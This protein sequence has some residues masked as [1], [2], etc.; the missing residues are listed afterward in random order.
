VRILIENRHQTVGRQSEFGTECA[1]LG[2]IARASSGAADEAE[3][4]AT[5][6]NQDDSALWWVQDP[7][8]VS[9]KRNGGGAIQRKAIA[10][11]KGDPGMGNP[12][13]ECKRQP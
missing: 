12:P 1:S 7:Q 4:P 8:H 3:C 5:K 10:V 11:A 13:R 6:V 2:H 9:R